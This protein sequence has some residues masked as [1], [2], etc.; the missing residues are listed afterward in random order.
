[1]TYRSI[2]FLLGYFKVLWFLV[3]AGRGFR[4]EG[5]REG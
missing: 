2:V 3:G 4:V 5:F 1:M